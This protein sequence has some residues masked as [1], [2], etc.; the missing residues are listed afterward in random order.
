MVD[1]PH[2]FSV[3]IIIL[4]LIIVVVY[5]LKRYHG[6]NSTNVSTIRILSNFSL[7]HKEKIIVVEVEGVRLVLGLAG[8]G[9][10]TLHV[11]DK[12]VR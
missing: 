9:F 10:E 4:L 7:G 2:I 6:V 8:R 5:L 1:F 11:L 12:P 3:L